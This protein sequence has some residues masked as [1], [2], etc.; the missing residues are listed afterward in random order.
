MHCKWRGCKVAIRTIP[1]KDKP[2]I[3]VLAD[4]NCQHLVPNLLHDH[5][6]V[7]YAEPIYTLEQVKEK[8]PKLD[9][10]SDILMLVGINNIKRPNATISGTVTQFE[11]TCKFVQ[12]QYPNACIHVGSVAPSCEKFIFFNAELENLAM[13]RNV[14]F[15]TALPILEV[16][17][18]GLRAKQN[19]L[20]DI[21]YTKS[22]FKLF[23]N[24]IKKTLHRDDIHGRQCYSPSIPQ[25]HSMN[26]QT[27]ISPLMPPE[28]QLP[29]PL[30][31]EFRRFLSMA[32]SVLPHVTV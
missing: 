2:V 19:T 9:N 12:N 8:L 23:A 6:K 26:H 16:T 1:E 15:I 32:L 27:S 31:N 18:F 11:Q 4:S 21:H 22:G 3:L 25:C 20:R 10:V 7:V 28:N 17:P 24:E 13:A 30:Q 5:K 29:F 14:P